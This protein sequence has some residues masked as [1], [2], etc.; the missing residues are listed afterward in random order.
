LEQGKSIK[1][2]KGLVDALAA[3]SILEGFL[4]EKNKTV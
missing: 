4:R 3:T 2:S 1:E